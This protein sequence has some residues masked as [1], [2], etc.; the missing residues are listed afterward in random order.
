VNPYK[1]T[2][3]NGNLLSGNGTKSISVKW[4]TT[5]GSVQVIE[6]QNEYCQSPEKVASVII[7]TSNTDP[8]IENAGITI[9]PNPTSGIFNIKTASDAQI[10]VL[11]Y[12]GKVLVNVNSVSN[13]EQ[14]VNLSDYS[15]G[16]Y[17]VVVTNGNEKQTLKIV[18]Y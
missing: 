17:Y 2:V 5:D 18:K 1:W 7:Q 9:R 6:N 15:Q 4:A 10:S 3:T 8:L 12:T 11:D 14:Q 16:I 13:L